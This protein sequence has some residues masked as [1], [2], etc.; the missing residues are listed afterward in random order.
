MTPAAHTHSA[1]H[2]KQHN[3]TPAQRLW[4]LG[5]LGAAI[6]LFGVV[7]VLANGRSRIAFTWTPQPVESTTTLTAAAVAGA[8]ELPAAFVQTTVNVE[9]QFTANPDAT[10]AA[11]PSTTPTFNGKARGNATITNRWSQV[12]PLQAGTRLRSPDGQIFRTQARVD[13]PVGGSVTTL[14]VADVAGEKGA[15]PTG[16]HFILPGLWVGL[17]DTITGEA[18]ENFYG[19][20]ASATSPALPGLTATE[21]ANAEAALLAE[22]A[23]T[24]IPELEKLVPDGRKLYPGLVSPSLTKRTGPSIGDRVTTYTLKL[25]VQATGVA[26]DPDALGPAANAVLA[27]TLPADLQLVS[28]NL[29]DFTFRVASVDLKKQR[30][31]VTVTARGKTA[32]TP[33]HPLLQHA[34]YAGKSAADVQALLGKEKAISN[35]TVELS[36]FWTRTIPSAK[37]DLQLE[38]TRAE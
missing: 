21:L 8:S 34:T 9:K 12:Q 35:I 22:A 17:Q 4:A 6:V 37:E 38:M 3:T 11:T 18:A 23:T 31:D 32:P 15:L 1:P 7:L 2:P 5:F 25:A 26:V 33:Q 36:P 30:A 29:N 16:T 28:M 19:E 27:G 14:V 24:A 10:P 20:G 13:V